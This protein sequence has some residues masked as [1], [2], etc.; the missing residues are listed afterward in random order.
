MKPGSVLVGLCASAAVLCAAPGLFAQE[1]FGEQHPFVLSLEHIGGVSH[2]EVEPEN[3][4]KTSTT[5]AGTFLGLIPPYMP[6]PRLGFHYFAAPPLTVGGIFHYSDN[7][8]YGESLL[9]GVRIGAG[10]PL[11][12]GTAIWLRGGIA[13]VSQDF[14]AF[15]VEYTD[16]RPGGEVL[17]VLQPVEHFGFLLGGMF[18]MGV[19]GKAEPTGPLGAATGGE[20]RDFDYME[21]GATFGVMADF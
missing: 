9:A 19:A 3:A 18:E 14:G 12:T 15:G 7:D 20:T 21:Y 2:I 13:Y 11:D 10:I 4:E 1:G 8:F 5:Q 17:L 16:V 6:L